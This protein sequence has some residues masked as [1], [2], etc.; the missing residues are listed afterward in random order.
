MRIRLAIVKN[1]VP[2]R[3]SSFAT[4]GSPVNRKSLIVGL[5]VEVAGSEE[6]VNTTNFSN[7]F[8]YRA[9]YQSLSCLVKIERN[10][11][12]AILGMFTTTVEV[13]SFSLLIFI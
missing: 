12:E 11:Q 4:A 10:F 7:K 2:E 9:Y 6:S 1:T 8:F 5:N 13:R 3:K